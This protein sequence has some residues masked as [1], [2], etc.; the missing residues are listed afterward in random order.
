MGKK[1]DS[2]KPAKPARRKGFSAEERRRFEEG[3][4][5]LA[6]RIKAHIEAIEASQMI[7]PEDLRI[8][9]NVRS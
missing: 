3:R 6:P 2:R 5:K 9:I 1:K 8:R 7:T 4:A